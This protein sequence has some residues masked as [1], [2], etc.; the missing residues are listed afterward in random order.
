MTPLVSR[1]CHFVCVYYFLSRVS[2]TGTSVISHPSV[3][4]YYITLHFTLQS[5]SGGRPIELPEA[6]VER[7]REDEPSKVGKQQE[8]GERRTRS[9]G[10]CIS[11]RRGR[12]EPAG[13]SRAFRRRTRK[14]LPP[15]G[16]SNQGRGWDGAQVWKPARTCA[17]VLT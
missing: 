4:S 1:A 2:A 9:G 7:R 6:D 3:I 5:Q 16:R 17:D 10:E 11:H 15:S 12:D 13:E 8:R 14:A